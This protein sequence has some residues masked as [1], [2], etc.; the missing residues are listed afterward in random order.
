MLQCM[1]C[2]ILY[3]YNKWG[4]KFDNGFSQWQEILHVELSDTT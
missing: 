4:N 1:R 3:N 2:K